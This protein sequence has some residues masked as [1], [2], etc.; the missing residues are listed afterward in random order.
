MTANYIEKEC[1]K[2][3]KTKCDIQGVIIKI[4]DK[5]ERI[6]FNRYK[7][8]SCHCVFLVKRKGDKKEQTL[9]E[10]YITS[11]SIILK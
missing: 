6:S 7:C 5:G 4:N 8:L 1:P 2:C 10:K 3:E 9:T 11:K